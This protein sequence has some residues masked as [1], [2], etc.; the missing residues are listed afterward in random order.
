MAGG[1]L[2][3]I[4]GWLFGTALGLFER[5]YVRLSRLAFSEAT[6]QSNYAIGKQQ[7]LAKVLSALMCGD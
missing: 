4:R 5:G 7:A 2:E 3:H 6:V 1:L